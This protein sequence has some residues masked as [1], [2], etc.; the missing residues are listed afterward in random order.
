MKFIYTLGALA[1]AGL[2][3]AGC[4]LDTEP[5]GG[6]VTQSQKE[7]TYK[8]DP[9]RA[10]AAATGLTALFSVMENVLGEGE[11]NDFGYPAIMAA[12]DCRGIDMVS[13]DLGYNWFRT[14]VSL[15]DITTTSPIPQLIWGTYYNQI[16]AANGLLTTVKAD[17][18]Q[19]TT[20]YYRAQALTIRA[21]DYF[22]LAQSFQFTY[23]GNEAKNCV[24][25]VTEQNAEEAAKK[26]VPFSTVEEVYARVNADLDSALVEFEAGNTARSDRRYVNDA[27]IYGLKAR[28]ALVQ[29]RWADAAAAAD[30]AISLAGTEGIV[31]ASREEV[32]HPTF[33]SLDEP[34]WMWGIKISETDR[35]V[36][37]TLVNWP[38]H[39]CSFAYGYTTVG[40]EKRVSETLFAAIP[41]TDVRKGWFATG[42][43]GALT[44]PNLTAAQSGYLNEIGM[45]PLTQVKFNS[46]KGVLGQSVNAS[47]I[48]LMRV[49]EMYL[50]KA[51]ALAMSGNVAGGVQTLTDFVKTYRDPAYS[52]TAASPEAVQ[53]AVW[54]QRRI[55]LWGEGLS[56]YDL[57]R[58]KKNLDRRGAGF[59]PNVTFNVPFNNTAMLF[60]IPEKEREAN[61]AIK[62][63][64]YNDTPEQ[65]KPVL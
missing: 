36:A 10:S 23:K 39:M 49:E 34:D 20:R 11:Q 37:S 12:T 62:S 13:P 42:D 44:S 3:L 52:L 54:M 26:G 7:R 18:R 48:P 9:K 59:E 50:I 4:T 27:V 1:L 65:P 43:A 60:T 17:D 58:L 15:T 55:E 31:P 47:D 51:E 5:M 21:F 32:N 24:P 25:V 35:V 63:N 28:V 16:K 61:K 64:Q 33:T 30:K 46:Y 6:F 2:S 19:P 14:T 38:G 45:S 41:S 53:E 22:M 29:Q 57:L 8:L 56:Y 40:V